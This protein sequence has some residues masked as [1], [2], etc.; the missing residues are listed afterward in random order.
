M[1]TSII[2]P[3]VRPEGLRLVDVSLRNQAI[4]DFE[5]LICGP[6]VMREEISK[7]IKFTKYR[8]V[9]NLP[10]KKDMYW[11]LNYSYNRLFKESKGE[12]CVSW[13]DW[14]YAGP[15]ALQKFWTNYEATDKKALIGT[16]GDQYESVDKFG[17]PQIKIWKDPRKRLDQGSFYEIFPS[18]LEWNFCA[19]PRKAIFDVG[20][21]CE[22]LDEKGFGMDGYQ[23]N[24]RLDL[25]GY[26]FFIDHDNESF[27]I[28]H[29]R[30]AHGGEENW[31]KNNNMTNGQYER[32]RQEFIDRG[33]WPRMK[34]L[35]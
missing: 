7:H 28:R 18:D 12:L 11:D 33:D 19:V 14:I 30:S 20:G 34:Y 35:V 25:L 1:K 15:D 29:D 10:L 4:K 6:E 17:K 27:T 13:Q 16:S 32:V 2:T 26:K 24:E 31:N 8:F 5:W 21:F 23:V 9:G 3:T 22:K